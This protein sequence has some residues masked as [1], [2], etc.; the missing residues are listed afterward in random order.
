MP[1][2]ISYT[3]ALCVS[4]VQCICC[5]RECPSCDVIRAHYVLILRDHSTIQLNGSPQ[6]VDI[7]S[8]PYYCRKMIFKISK[9]SG[10]NFFLY[11]F[12]TTNERAWFYGWWRATHTP[13]NHTP[14]L[15]SSIIN[16]YEK[17]L[18]YLHVPSMDVPTSSEM[19]FRFLRCLRE[20]TKQSG[21]LFLDIFGMCGTK[22]PTI[23][24]QSE[25]H[26]KSHTH[27]NFTL[28]QEFVMEVIHCCV[29]NGMAS[30]NLSTCHSV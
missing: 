27:A 25:F 21:V 13:H 7:G 9:F 18:F 30:L 22:I 26:P 14:V 2:M 29:F 19:F 23:C 1:D 8:C 10:L 5:M 6:R 24:I 28:F 3:E 4:S 11:C 20:K 17:L 15:R 16:G 12:Y